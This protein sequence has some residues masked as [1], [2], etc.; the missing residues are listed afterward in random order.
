MITHLVRYKLALNSR[1]VKSNRWKWSGVKMSMSS[2]KKPKKCFNL[3]EL[4]WIS[5]ALK[6]S[7][8]LYSRAMLKVTLVPMGLWPITLSWRN[9]KAITVTPR[10]RL[11]NGFLTSW[12]ILTM[13]TC[14]LCLTNGTKI[15]KTKAEWI[16]SQLYHHSKMSLPYK[17]TKPLLK[18]NCFVE[19]V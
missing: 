9:A 3:M 7:M 12:S 8:N 2:I 19:L 16:L 1:K 10:I 14:V 13:F 6:V 17:L 5:I 11:M 18:Q 15:L 4:P